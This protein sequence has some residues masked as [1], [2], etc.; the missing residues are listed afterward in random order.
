[1]I[2]RIITAVRSLTIRHKLILTICAGALFAVFLTSTIILEHVSKLLRAEL[3][4]KGMII[5]SDLATQAVDPIL[6]DDPWIM[7]GSVKTVATVPRLPGLEYMMVLDKEGRVLAHSDPQ[8]FRTGDPL[9]DGPFNERALSAREMIV[10]EGSV[11]GETLYDITAPVRMGPETLGFARVGLTDRPTRNELAAIKRDIYF[12]A[13]VLS[14]G[15]VGISI[16]VAYHITG[17]L[18]RVMQNIEKIKRGHVRDVFPIEAAEKDEIGKLVQIFNEMASSLKTQ[19]ELDEYLA[20]KDKLAMLGEFSAGLAHE[21]KNPLTS[22]KMLMQSATERG[23]PLCV[24][25]VEIV[26]GEINRID[27][28]V[29]EFLIFARPAQEEHTST[30][31]NAILR[32]AAALIKPEMEKSG[33]S[34]MDELSDDAGHIR[35]HQAGFRQ[36]VLNI[37]LNAGQAMERGGVLTLRSFRADGHV[38]VAVSDTGPG[39]R[40]SDLE[41]IF[42]PFFTTKED[43]TGMGLAIV[44]RIVREHGGDV[45]VDTNPGEGTTFSVRM[46]A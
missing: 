14:V 18:Q 34:F 44:D 46:R 36:V 33:I 17:P 22:I 13:L 1:M 37:M 23:V 15:G 28:V 9:P 24:G 19:Q 41:R 26:E 5:A 35:A 39:I 30:D 11:T 7:Y 32:E 40:A 38:T 10:Q 45:Q 31:V 4:N 6:Y 25:D 43:G 29:R 21:I 2:R 8:R 27:R 16:W 3:T 42:D 12:V 20:R